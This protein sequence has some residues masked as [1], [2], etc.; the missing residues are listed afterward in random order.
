MS[1]LINLEI[2]ESC[3]LDCCTAI[4]ILTIDILDRGLAEDIGF[5]IRKQKITCSY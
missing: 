4:N 2:S 3:W 1:G 5:N